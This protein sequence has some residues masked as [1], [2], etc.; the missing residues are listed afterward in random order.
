ML[1]MGMFVP[2]W[3][4]ILK[5]PEALAFLLELAFKGLIWE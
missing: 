3:W 4:T 1:S 2:P 5:P